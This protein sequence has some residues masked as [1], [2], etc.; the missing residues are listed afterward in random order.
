MYKLCAATSLVSLAMMVAAVSWLG[1][2]R[3]RQNHRY[4]WRL[5]NAPGRSRQRI[6]ATT[7][8]IVL[9]LAGTFGYT[10]EKSN[11]SFVRGVWSG[12]G[13][14]WWEIFYGL[15]ALVLAVIFWRKGLREITL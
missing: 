3:G 7:A 15:V 13:V 10:I 14:V 11:W 6:T 8:A 2:S 9:I 1:C 5:A 12:G 4:T